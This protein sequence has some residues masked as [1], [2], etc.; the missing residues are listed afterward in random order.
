MIACGCPVC[1]ST[2]KKNNRLRSSILVRSATTTIVIDTTPDFRYQML[3]AQVKHLDA[4]VFTHPH[5]D[6]IAGL[7]D[8]RAFNF[9]SGKGMPI[10]ANEMT[11]MNIIRE[12]PYA[13]AETKYPGVPEIM[14]HPIDQEAFMVG[15]IRI[16]PITVWH[17]RMPVLGFRFGS[18]TYITDANHIGDAEKE[19]IR[20][21][22]HLVLNALRKEKHISHFSLS[23]AIEMA[24]ELGV[25]N[26]YFTHISHQLGLH[27]EVDPTLPSGMHLA[28]DGLQLEVN[29]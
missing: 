13:F 2:D 21:S 4:V 18:F 7:D 5:K 19:K 16:E 29:G 22:S 28:Y 9:F 3:R 25:T 6:H 27:A 12:F 1:T 17:M 10:Y 11:Q 15:D 26:A 24:T 20:G 23:E 14:I 8:V